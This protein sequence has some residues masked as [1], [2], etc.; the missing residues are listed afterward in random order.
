MTEAK[1]GVLNLYWDK[2]LPILAKFAKKTKDKDLEHACKV[3]RSFNYNIRS[4]FLYA[5][6]KQCKVLH[7]IAFFQWR[8]IFCTGANKDQLQECFD[9][10]IGNA[11]KY[12][13][14]LA[15]VKKTKSLKHNQHGKPMIGTLR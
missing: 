15:C 1:H 14:S 2:Q 11:L 9:T 7:Q 8:D 13:P 12:N 6:L 5:Y 10:Q 4:K 3:I